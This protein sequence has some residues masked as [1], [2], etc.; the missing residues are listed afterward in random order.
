MVVGGWW[1]GVGVAGFDRQIVSDMVLLNFGTQPYSAK[2]IEMWVE[3]Y[4]FK[5]GSRDYIN[6]PLFNLFPIL[7]AYL[8]EDSCIALEIQRY[9][10]QFV[11]KPISNSV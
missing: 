2:L 3:P 6:T 1:F 5:Y 11:F 7:P 4:S 10:S 8:C 9:R